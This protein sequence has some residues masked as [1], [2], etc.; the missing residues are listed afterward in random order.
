MNPETRELF[1]FF[2]KD[3]DGFIYENQFKQKLDSLKIM[4]NW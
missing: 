3:Q 4:E 1:K 2:D